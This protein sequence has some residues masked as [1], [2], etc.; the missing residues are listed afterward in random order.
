VRT[1]VGTIAVLVGI[2]AGYEVERYV[3]HSR[4]SAQGAQLQGQSVNASIVAICGVKPPGFPSSGVRAPLT[5]DASGMLCTE[6]GGGGGNGG[7]TAYG[8]P[9]VVA[10]VT[11]TIFTLSTVSTIVT[12]VSCGNT[13]TGNVWAQFFNST[14]ATTPVASLYL[15]PG[16]GQASTAPW[17]FD[18]ALR[19]R[20]ATSPDGATGAPAN[21]VSCT[22][23]TR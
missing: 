20:A 4:V 16:G 19:I 3:E 12:S 22:I 10:D 6:A 21:T 1:V 9:R 14:T 17:V 2:G 18:T 15:P 8:T 5:I 13:G 23:A 7:S 11:G